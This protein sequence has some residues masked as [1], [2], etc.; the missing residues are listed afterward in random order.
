MVIVRAAYSSR[1]PDKPVQTSRKRKRATDGD[2]AK[3][4]KAADA[5]TAIKNKV[6]YELE[7]DAFWTMRSSEIARIAK[8]C[9][10][11][12]TVVR[13]MLANSS[14]FK[15]TRL[16][17]KLKVLQEE[18]AEEMEDGGFGTFAEYAE[19]HID[20]DEK[21]RL[22]DQLVEHRELQDRGVRMT[23]K[24]AQTDARQTARVIGEECIDLHERTGTHVVGFMSCGHPD[25]P[26]KP[27]TFD[28][29]NSLE[30][31]D[32]VYGIS[33]LDMIRAFELWC[34]TRDDTQPDSNDIVA[35]RKEIARWI[36]DGL[37]TI[38]SNKKLAMKYVSY[39]IDIRELLKVQLVGWPTEIP[40]RTPV[41]LPA[42]TARR[43][44]DMLRTGD[45]HW[46]RIPDDE[47]AKLVAKLNRKR[48]K[49]PNGKLKTRNPRSDAGKVRGARK[50][51]TAEEEEEEEE[52]EEDEGE[53][54]EEE[55][56]DEAEN[57]NENENENE[58]VAPARSALSLRVDAMQTAQV[59]GASLSKAPASRRIFSAPLLPPMS[60]TS[61]STTSA[62]TA[63][64]SASHIMPLPP[65]TFISPL[66]PAAPTPLISNSD[67]G[68]DFRLVMGT[69]LDELGLPAGDWGAGL[70]GARDG[71][72]E[73]DL[74]RGMSPFDLTGVPILNAQHTAGPF[75][76]QAAY[77]EI[78]PLAGTI[79][80]RVPAVHSASPPF[81]FP[82]PAAVP[83][84]TPLNASPPS[85]TGM[86]GTTSVFAART[87]T[88]AA[89]VTHTNA[90]K[91]R[92]AVDP[93]T[94]L[95]AENDE[96]DATLAKKARKKRSDAGKPRPKDGKVITPDAAAPK[97][98]RKK[99]SDAGKPR[100]RKDK[101]SADSDGEES[102]N[103]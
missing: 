2:A 92:K 101:D 54:D 60:P 64:T 78:D 25:D 48:A 76:W 72:Q 24:A 77:G 8:K 21:K 61:A 67:G 10:K 20:E 29:D 62:G 50:S 36:V 71:V 16:V 15:S 84:T 53:D 13:R 94:P 14:R 74:L 91:K 18:F 34:C 17:K 30:F 89:G 83:P 1:H 28:S 57:E 55:E 7:I 6:E 22:I 11:S 86:G 47:H 73:I 33:Y 42:E 38:K 46:A 9:H 56:E 31:F 4:T 58:P 103:E 93:A 41:R 44:R 69:G 32:Q 43:I 87:N 52:E 100:P 75:Q 85:T 45:I 98:A 96:S 79:F 27:A 65:P 82:T 3:R 19:C 35:V 49:A 40:M 63:P 23:D 68:D 66:F 88:T 26:C 102:P 80:E 59:R 39:D 90:A 95:S 97:R 99:R 70:P 12:E 5:A 81:T 51:K 37:R